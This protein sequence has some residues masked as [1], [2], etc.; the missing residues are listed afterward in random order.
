MSMLKKE[1]KEKDYLF[2][3]SDEYYLIEN[4]EMREVKKEE[5]ESS[6]RK[7]NKELFIYSDGSVILRKK[8]KNSGGW[9]VC[10]YKRGEIIKTLS[11]SALDVT[12]NEMELEGCLQA[13]LYAHKYKDTYSITLNLDCD[14]L[15]EGIAVNYR[16]WQNQG[17]RTR[18]KKRP[19][20]YLEK[21]HKIMALIET[22]PE[23]K[24]VKVSGHSGVE[25]NEIVDK[26]ARKIA[27]ERMRKEIENSEKNKEL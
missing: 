9:A 22:M 25:G 13:L 27:H 26:L 14:Y 19:V 11:G 1:E 15:I 16:A 5:P 6:N 21:W 20:S 8:R 4:K 2:V 12:S 10:I 3:E 24:I 18:A 7:A 17:F 23:I